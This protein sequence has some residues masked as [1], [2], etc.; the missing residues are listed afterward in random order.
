ML[1]M[2]ILIENNKQRSDFNIVVL[3]TKSVGDVFQNIIAEYVS[4]AFFDW[5]FTRKHNNITIE[6]ILSLGLLNE[7]VCD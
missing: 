4:T 2:R 5:L 1:M 3:N 6:Y 7:C